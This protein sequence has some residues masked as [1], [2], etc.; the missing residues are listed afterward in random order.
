VRCIM[1]AATIER[2]SRKLEEAGRG[3]TNIP[4]QDALL[5]VLDSSVWFFC[6]FVLFFVVVVLFCFCFALFLFYF[7]FV[8]K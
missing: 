1:T 8:V 6:L 5:T 7:G 2:G 4:S 3:G